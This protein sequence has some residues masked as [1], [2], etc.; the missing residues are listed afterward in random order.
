M[1]SCLLEVKSSVVSVCEELGWNTLT[2][3]NFQWRQLEMTEKLLKP[4]A[5][6]TTLTSGEES[7]NISLVIPILLELEM[8]LQ[9][10]IA[11]K[12]SLSTIAKEMLQGLKQRFE[13][14]TDPSAAKFDPLFVTATYLNPPYREI[15]KDTQIKTAKQYLLKLCKQ[16]ESEAD[17]QDDDCTYVPDAD[18]VDNHEI[19]PPSKRPKLLSRVASLIE[20]KKK[21]SNSISSSLSSEEKEVERYSNDSFNT[22]LDE[23][24]FNFWNTIKDYPIIAPVACDILCVPP[25]TAPVERVFSTSGESTS[26]KC[27]RL[28]DNNLE[29]E[30]L[31]RKNKMYLR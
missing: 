2:L 8:H 14:A 24:P 13:Y 5:Q 7:T 9:D 29:R 26:G 23:D 6:Y 27:N 1:I 11:K 19:S 15:L 25:S 21:Q 30:V 31:L 3:S 17:L 10:E 16:P 28:T 22:E 20:E 12:S 18:P 4:F